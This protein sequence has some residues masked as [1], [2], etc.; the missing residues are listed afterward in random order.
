[1]ARLL[2]APATSRKAPR[3]AL[4]GS[5]ATVAVPLRVKRPLASGVPAAGRTR[6]FCQVSVQRIP[7]LLGTVT[8]KVSWVDVT[9][10]IAT[11]VP[12][13]T[14][15]MFLEAD[16]PLILTVGAVPAVSTTHPAGATRMR[17]TVP[18]L[19]L[20]FSGEVRPVTVVC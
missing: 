13:E 6:T 8:V 17:V 2:A 9:D 15:L 11:E 18:T 4:M 3:L 19:S 12:L 20:V 10:V 1:M 14:P 5:P 16:P 7:P